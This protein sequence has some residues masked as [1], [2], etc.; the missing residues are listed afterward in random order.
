M[1]AIIPRC[2]CGNSAGL[3][4]CCAKTLNSKIW[5]GIPRKKTIANALIDLKL[6]LQQRKFLIAETIA[7]R[8]IL[9]V[10]IHPTAHYLLGMSAFMQNDL[11]TATINIRKAFDYG[12][13]DPVAHL[14]YAN[15]VG[16][17]GQHHLA[18]HHLKS[19]VTLQSDYHKAWIMGYELSGMV[20]ATESLNYFAQ[21]LVKNFPEVDKHWYYAANAYHANI[22]DEKAIETLA[23]GLELFPNSSDLQLSL[24]AILE[25]QHKLKEAKKLVTKVLAL[26]PERVDAQVLQAKIFRRNGC[27]N[28]ALHTL[29][30]AIKT[31]STDDKL[32][33]NIHAEYI[34]LYQLQSDYE[35]VWLHALKMNKAI[36]SE[37]LQQ[38][39]WQQIKQQLTEIKNNKTL[40]LNKICR[41][42]LL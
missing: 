25:L 27:L 1:V 39:Q 13:L 17:N 11:G 35:N 16:Q 24:A 37:R 41:W 21:G 34:A 32:L 29:N 2:S 22:Q 20:G 15:I 28:D 42:H 31:V 14:N 5:T 7:E 9:K 23:T 26:S 30:V 40:R 8:I 4:R 36:G 3:K 18:L 10:P 19:A 6:A 12:L 33:S 38:G